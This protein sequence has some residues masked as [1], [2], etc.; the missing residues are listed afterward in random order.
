MSSVSING[1]RVSSTAVRTALAKG[2]LERAAILLGRPYSISGRVVH[3]DG[4]GRSLGFP[5]ANVHMKHNRPALTGI[6]AVEVHG[7]GPRPVSGVASLGVRPTVTDRGDA[8]LEVYLLDFSQD[9][10]GRHVRVDFLE[11]FR[12]E[13]KFA[14]LMALTQ[15]IAAD[16]ARARLFFEQ[17]SRVIQY[18]SSNPNG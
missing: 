8:V 15:Q 17:R 7:V 1:E 9:V 10:Y 3:G 16:V 13:Q 18:R 11:K 4:L 6:F 12:D 2:E 5:T 14:D